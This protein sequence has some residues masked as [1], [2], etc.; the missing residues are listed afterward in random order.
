MQ[1]VRWLR[2]LNCWVNCSV[3]VQVAIGGAEVSTAGSVVLC[4]VHSVHI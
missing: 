2:G 4:P 3:A 1:V